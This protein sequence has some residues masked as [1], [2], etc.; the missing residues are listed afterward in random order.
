MSA[1]LDV[2]L[3]FASLFCFPADDPPPH[4]IETGQNIEPSVSNKLQ[5]G[6]DQSSAKRIAD[7]RPIP[8]HVSTRLRRL[9]EATFSAN[10]LKRQEAVIRMRTIREFTTAGIPFAVRLLNDPDVAVRCSAAR[11]LARVR[12]EKVVD[13][14]VLLLADEN[15]EVRIAA[16]DALGCIKSPRALP[17]L[18]AVVRNKHEERSVRSSAACALRQIG[19]RGVAEQ[20]LGVLTDTDDDVHV[21]SVVAQVVAE[22]GGANAVVHLTAILEGSQGNRVDAGT[23][24][25]ENAY[26]FL[27]GDQLRESVADVLVQR[28][29]EF[30]V[31]GVSELNVD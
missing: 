10:A 1:L 7:S 5:T 11:T 26:L 3:I 4:T 9:I 15:L 17:S 19:N 30:R 22:Q 12:N 8:V 23:P 18:L 16:T 25:A 29:V 31:A 24:G 14:L 28:N 2:I 27:I 20:L 13:S 21:R 6:H